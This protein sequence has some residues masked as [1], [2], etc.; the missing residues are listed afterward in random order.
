VEKPGAPEASLPFLIRRAQAGDRDAFDRLVRMHRDQIFRWALVRIGDVDDAEDATQEVLVRLHLGLRKFREASRF[1][2]WLYAI[3]RNAAA[4]VSRRKRNRK[5]MI[6][7]YATLADGGKGRPTDALDALAARRLS[8]LVR[9]F[10][11]E[12]P[13]RQREAVDL[14]DLQGLA[15]IEAAELLG[16]NPATLRTHLFRG[17]R[18]LRLR[19]LETT[20]PG[21]VT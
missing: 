14:V 21:E 15:P 18:A 1:E 20:E 4:D 9:D 12:L 6:D 13:A 3:T 10:L 7:R 17:R 16:S 5:S 19:L 11:T 2:T 8:A